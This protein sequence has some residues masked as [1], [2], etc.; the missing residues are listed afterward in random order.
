MLTG[1]FPFLSFG[2]GTRNKKL[3]SKPYK[4]EVSSCSPGKDP[5][6]ITKLIQQ[7]PCEACRMIQVGMG[8]GGGLQPQPLLQARSALD[9]HQLA[10]ALIQLSHSSLQGWR[11]CR[12]SPADPSAVMSAARRYQGMAR[13]S[14]KCDKDHQLISLVEFPILSTRIKAMRKTVL[15]KSRVKPTL[16]KNTSAKPS[17][18]GKAQ[19]TASAA[20]LG[21]IHPLLAHGDLKP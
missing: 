18:P 11:L 5:E 15:A 17:S 4:F 9:S 3:V 10:Q 12:A 8:L 1:L 16:T 20:A 2:Q 6:L 14:Q 19:S 13:E 21:K 7:P